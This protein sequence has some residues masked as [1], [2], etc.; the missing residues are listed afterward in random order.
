MAVMGVTM[1]SASVMGWSFRSLS[2][3]SNEQVSE[4]VA[5]GE[6]G[7]QEPDSAC[8][9]F[10]GQDVADGDVR[11]EGVAASQP[12]HGLEPY[13]DVQVPFERSEVC[14]QEV[15]FKRL[16]P[17]G[18]SGHRGLRVAASGGQQSRFGH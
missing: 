6:A 8:L 2:W 3:S 13:G 15:P 7:E 4:V 12:A 14:V 11:T 10:G 1:T 16:P 5:R 9:A 17:A 18:P